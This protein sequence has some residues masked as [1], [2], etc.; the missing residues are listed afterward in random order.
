MKTETKLLWTR[1]VLFIWVLAAL[2]CFWR[3]REFKR[4]LDDSTPNLHAK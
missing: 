2:L 3:V 4:A 1:M